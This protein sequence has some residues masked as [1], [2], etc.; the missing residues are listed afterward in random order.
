MAWQALKSAIGLTAVVI[1][2]SLPFVTVF[3][4]FYFA[5][6]LVKYYLSLPSIIAYPAVIAVVLFSAKLLRDCT[7][8][9][10]DHVRRL[11]ELYA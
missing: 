11:N 3:A 7:G 4:A 9:K 2:A 1:L 6:Q 10:I 5:V 8:H